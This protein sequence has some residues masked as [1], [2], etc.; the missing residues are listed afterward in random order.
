MADVD[1]TYLDGPT[2]LLELEG[3][4]LLTDPTFDPPGTDYPFPGY[5]LH[6][7]KESPLSPAALPEIDAVLLSHDHHRDNL[8]DAGREFAKRARSVLTTAAGA[9]R[10][11]SPA[12]GL[13]PGDTVTLTGRDG[14]SLRITA[15]PARH[16]PPGGDRGPVIGFLLEPTRADTGCVYVSGDT[17]W[18]EEVA[19]LARRYP[20][21]LAVLFLGAAKVAPAGPSHLTFTAAEAVE[22]ARAFGD[23]A[24][25]PLHF[26][27]WAHFTESRAE[28]SAAF[29]AARL[30]DRLI[31]PE[32][33]RPIRIAI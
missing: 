21:K 11:G 22:A 15:T 12:R 27:G 20:I 1:F 4:R 29:A 10:L 13:N 19:Q 23:A 17:V 6:K 2:A 8:D 5:T 25:I 16:G 32:A 33:G 28:I 14:R 9:T 24:I 26:E 7:T 3:L 30:S 18:Y 31:W